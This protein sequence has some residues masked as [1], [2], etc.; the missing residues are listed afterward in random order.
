MSA[1]SSHRFSIRE[2]RLDDIGA[3]V[4][5]ERSTEH[6]PRWGRK[7]YAEMTQTREDQSGLRRHLVVGFAAACAHPSLPDSSI[8]ESIAVAPAAQRA[9]VGR[10][11][12]EA[13][14]A[15]CQAQG[16]EEMGL[17]VR[18]QS[19][20]VIAF[21]MG[22]GFVEV[23]VRPAYYSDSVDDALVMRLKLR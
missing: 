14:I 12:C 16:A 15:W 11:L 5:L 19:A 20:G 17:E 23:A 3:I 13:I 22:L 7:A 1:G 21:Y 2:A 10:T 8:L 18:G 9:G 4:A 6:A